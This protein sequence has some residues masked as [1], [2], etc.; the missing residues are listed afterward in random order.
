[1]PQF[2]TLEIAQLV[3]ADKHTDVTSTITPTWVIPISNTDN[4][5]QETDQLVNS[6][7]TESF[8]QLPPT[9]L[10][11]TAMLRSFFIASQHFNQNHQQCSTSNFY[12]HI[13]MVTPMESPAIVF[14]AF[15]ALMSSLLVW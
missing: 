15:N 6:S 4:Q 7:A 11:C 12:C 3:N 10:G 2:V 13:A 9:R 1:M 14:D 8:S 5:S